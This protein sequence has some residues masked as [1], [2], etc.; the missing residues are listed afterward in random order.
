MFFALAVSDLAQATKNP[1][2]RFKFGY[3]L[4][5]TVA[6][7][8]LEDIPRNSV[9]F[10][11]PTLLWD[12]PA[13][14]TK[15]GVHFSGELI[16]DFGLMPASGLGVSLYFYPF[17]ISSTYMTN[18]DMVMY[19]KSL[20]S[21]YL[22]FGMTPLNLNMN[23]SSEDN[24]IQPVFFSAFILEFQAGIGVDYP[25]RPSFVIHAEFN[26]RT[27]ATTNNQS[28]GGDISSFNPG[29]TLGFMLNYPSN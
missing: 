28:V 19:Q 17:G 5:D 25:L 9:V 24:S 20:T 26:I 7:A 16:S 13:I 18:D 14:R 11:Q 6:G 2:F 29:V 21:P 1:N 15:V 27:G 23:R 8:I 3:F 10:I 12:V 4:T 22:F